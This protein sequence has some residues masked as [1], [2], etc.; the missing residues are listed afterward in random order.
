MDTAGSN[1]SPY[2][3]WAK[4]ATDLQTVADLATA[5]DIIY[6]RGTQT[7][8]TAITFDTNSG[9]DTGYIKV[10]GC[11]ASGDPDGTYFVLDGN[12]AAANCIA[13]DGALC[14]Q[15]WLESIEIKNATT[16]GIGFASTT[17]SAGCVFCNLYIHDNTDAGI[18]GS[19]LP[20]LRLI[21]CKIVDNGGYGVERHKCAP[22][23]FCLITG[24]TGGIQAA[25]NY[26]SNVGCIIHD[27]GTT[28][29]SNTVGTTVTTQVFVN[30][31]FDS[32]TNNASQALDLN[33]HDILIGCRI[34]NYSTYIADSV[35]PTLFIGCY[36]DLAKS[37]VPAGQIFE[38]IPIF[39]FSAGT[40]TADNNTW[41]GTDTGDGYENVATGDYNL[42]SSATGRSQPIQL[43]S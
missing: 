42:T 35:G 23:A 15:L 22:M 39:D 37:A 6:C 1:T 2:D 31:I 8:T 32:Y 43:P 25:Q 3:T 40:R 30:C 11:N 38:S 4:A 34:T 33:A 14:N 12:S 9:D 16:D 21:Q 13:I 18:Y 19:Y 36:S 26:G 17:N 41:S 28:N 10:I 29:D 7:L 20:G 24:N 27:N 5:A